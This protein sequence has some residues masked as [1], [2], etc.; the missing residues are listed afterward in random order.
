M[1][2]ESTRFLGSFRSSERISCI[3]I[4][5]NREE[6]I[7][8]AERRVILYFTEKKFSKRREEWRKART[9]EAKTNAI[10]LILQEKD[11]ILYLITT[12]R[13]I[14]SYGKI[15][16]KAFHQIFS[17]GESKHMLCRLAAKRI[18][19]TKILQVTLK[20]RGVRDTLKCELG[21]KEVWTP[22]VVLIRE[23]RE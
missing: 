20:T 8:R 11:G 1:T 13:T 12:S 9:S 18:C 14:S 21:K 22:N 7:A 10:L 19:E 23:L 15:S 3:V 6:S 2:K 4:I 16:R 17:E 5:L